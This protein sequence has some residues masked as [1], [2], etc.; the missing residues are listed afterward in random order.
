[1]VWIKKSS[2]GPNSETTTSLDSAVG[3][4]SDFLKKHFVR[5]FGTISRHK[6]NSPVGFQRHV[7]L[8]EQYGNV[9]NILFSVTHAY[10]FVAG[11]RGDGTG[12]SIVFST[13]RSHTIFPTQHSA[14]RQQV[15]CFVVMVIFFV[16][17]H[18]FPWDIFTCNSIW[19]PFESWPWHWQNS[20]CLVH[21]PLPKKN[22]RA[23]MRRPLLL[24]LLF[25]SGMMMMMM[26]NETEL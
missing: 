3:N 23:N 1:M 18:S 21:N 12:F 20:L 9:M 22:F 15:F 17:R 11:F 5:I 26:N 2:S 24:C 14:I 4:L 7:S 13:A 8:H 16:F 10:T 25:F 19:V 6:K